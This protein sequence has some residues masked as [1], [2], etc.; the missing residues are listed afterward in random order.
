LNRKQK[1]FLAAYV[2]TASITRSAKAAKLDRSLHYLWL[3]DAEYAGAFENTKDQAA[4]L[5]EDEAV[6]RAHQGVEEP[7]TW[8]G[9]FTYKRRAVKDAEGNTTLENYGKPLSIN[10]KSD[11]LLQFLLKGFRPDKYRDRVS[12]EV[13]G[14][15][16]GPISLEHDV[17]KK[18]SDDELGTLIALAEK[19]SP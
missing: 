12:A 7:L 13:S 11:A 18:L 9:Q 14:P 17:L 3:A 16:G 8:Q 1:A 5:L 10:R 15:A 6:R 4:Q 2:I 19:L